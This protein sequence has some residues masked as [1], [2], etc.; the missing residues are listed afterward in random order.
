MAT[1]KE[2]NDE[3]VE[4]VG[5]ME[6]M[7][8]V[9][10]VDW[11]PDHEARF[12]EVCDGIEKKT[13][14][15]VTTRHALDAESARN[16]RIDE[17]TKTAGD[18]KH[19]TFRRNSPYGVGTF[20]YDS[21]ELMVKRS[22]ERNHNA[23]IGWIRQQSNLPL[24]VEHR[25]ACDELKL[26]FRQ[27]ALEARI[28]PYDNL[29]GFRAWERGNAAVQVHFDRFIEMRDQS[30][31]GAE[32]GF[33]IPQGFQRELERALLDF[34][35]LRRVCRVWA[36]SGF[37]PIPWPTVDDSSNKA[38][39]VAEAADV[40]VSVDPTYGEVLFSTFK[41]GTFT[42]AS[43]ELLEDSAFNLSAMLASMLGE[44]IGRGTAE[45]F[46]TGDGTGKPTGI[47]T[48]SAE[49]HSAATAAFDF[50]DI[51]DL[52]HSVDPAYR[53]FAST[54]FV[55]NDT[56]LLAMRKTKDLEGRYIWNPGTTN[57]EPDRVWGFP[58]QIDQDFPDAAA[59]TPFMVF[60]ALEKFVIRDHASFRF[61]QLNELFRKTDQTGFI[62]FS[63]HD[64]HLIDAGTEPIKHMTA[65]A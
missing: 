53:R 40:G 47:L 55:F 17:L 2:L 36:T 26:D 51:L 4:L 14:A 41:Y 39:I 9:D 34:G 7:R 56:T 27:H 22:E 62:A 31:V 63:R 48:D 59:A 6:E 25:Q 16:T 58:Y 32:G 3:K 45:H 20:G 33:T 5:R 37:N 38:T 8:K 42:L 19:E 10:P 61:M 15:M 18:A 12:N 24:K 23:L 11:T 54:G 65:T 52:I 1:L 49:G 29:R 21:P 50:D 13:E 60:G 30:T 35:G 46:A 44:R 64:S 28:K 43:Q 57:S